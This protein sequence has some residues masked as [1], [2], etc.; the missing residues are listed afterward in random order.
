MSWISCVGVPA[1]ASICAPLTLMQ[2]WPRVCG[3]MWS[4][5]WQRVITCFTAVA[6]SV[7]VS[8]S[9]CLVM[10][11]V[12]CGLSY[13]KV[14]SLCES[15]RS[16]TWKGQMW[17]KASVVPWPQQ[18]P[19]VRACPVPAMSVLEDWMWMVRD[20]SDVSK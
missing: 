9:A 20:L 1:L 16:A 5:C 6:S 15:K 13:L 10:K 12:S 7:A 17:L 8:G 11:R 18:H 4:E 2:C 14:E 19:W 3:V